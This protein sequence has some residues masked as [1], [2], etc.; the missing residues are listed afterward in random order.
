VAIWLPTFLTG[1][2]ASGGLAASR[3]S[4]T[5]MLVVYNVGG[6]VCFPLFGV[7]SDRI[8][9][10]PAVLFFA[11]ISTA[12]TP[13]A[14]MWLAHLDT[15]LPFYVALFV[16]GGGVAF[17]AYYGAGISELFPTVARGTALGFINNIG[18][19]VGGQAP[20][21]IWLMA[22][23]YGFGDAMSFVAIIGFAMT[24]MIAL[25]M[26]ETKAVELR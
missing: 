15:P 5:A 3:T 25:F 21:F 17:F 16:S 20:V 14:Y 23:R 11:L 10:K 9:R 12:V 13:V 6:L 2:A 18:R 7:L 24:T 22:G 26:R 4:A 1:A 8:G 19:I